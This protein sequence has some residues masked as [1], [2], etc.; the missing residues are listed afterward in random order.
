MKRQC[1][2]PSLM[3]VACLAVPAALADDAGRLAGGW[4]LLSYEMEVQSSG[5]KETP[6]GANP[7][8]YI[9]FSADGRM[10]VVVTGEGRKPA[11][12]DADRAELFKTLVA[13]AG[14]YRVQGDRW[15]TKVEVAHNPAWVGGEQART[16]RLEADRLV[17]LTA[18]VNRPDKGPVRFVLTW[19]RAKP[20]G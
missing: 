15:I 9:Q 20:A 8:G 16:F 4:R 10:S 6:M 17:E 14:T 1:K 2:V 19:T 11:A 13:Y 7:A 5:V 18:L 3:L 12:T